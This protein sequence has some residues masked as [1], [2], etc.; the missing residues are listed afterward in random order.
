[1]RSVAW[2]LR[3]SLAEKRCRDDCDRS[4]IDVDG[5]ADEPEIALQALVADGEELVVHDVLLVVLHVGEVE[6]RQAHQVGPHG[7]GHELVAG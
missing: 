4:V 1:M 3:R 2:W 6:G 5:A 7:A